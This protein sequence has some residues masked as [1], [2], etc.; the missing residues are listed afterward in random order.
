MK[1]LLLVCIGAATFAAGSEAEIDSQTLLQLL[2]IRRLYVDKL[3]GGD[4]AVQLRDMLITSMQSAKLFILTENID[5]ADV[6]M[7]GSGE[8]LVFT[9]VFSSSDGVN[10]RV[11]LGSGSTA[12]TRGRGYSVGVGENESS[13]IQERKHEATVSV[14]LVTKDGDVI[15]STTQESTGA[16][17]RGASAD[18]ADKVTRQLADDFEKARKLSTAAANGPKQVTPSAPVR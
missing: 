17:F 6:I 2:N 18:V 9:D 15:W 13:R 1:R 3:N 7:R 10:A 14:R 4:T 12:A 8:D 5:K 11:T 16:K